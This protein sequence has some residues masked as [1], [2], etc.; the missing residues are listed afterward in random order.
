MNKN[1]SLK[2]FGKNSLKIVEE[3]L[4]E[5]KDGE[6][7][8]K[9]IACGLCASDLKVIE[10]KKEA[11][12]GITL[13]HEIVGE[14][15][16]SKNEMVKEKK[17]VSVFPSVVCR[18]CYSCNKGYYNLCRS[19]KSLGYYLDGGFARYVVVPREI[20]EI[21]GLIE[22]E[23]IPEILGAI[24]EPVGCVINSLKA[25][26]IQ[27]IE[28]LLIVGAGSLGLFHLIIANSY[29]KRVAIVDHN[30]DRL[31][32]ARELGARNT[33]SSIKGVEER[34]DAIVLTAPAYDEVST[35]LELLNERGKL[36]IF[37]GSRIDTINLPIKS[38]HYHE[39]TITGTHS[40]TPEYM[41]E[42]VEVIKNNPTSF[43]K[44]ITHIF[45]LSKWKDAIRYYKTRKAVKILITPD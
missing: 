21:G 8:I 6:V 1:L 3:P 36:N 12:I 9:V 30:E 18:N 27:D 29:K 31:N 39:R 22:I 25:I 15:V 35:I 32:L 23:G 28:N 37:A 24:I 38:F 44:V 41:K 33:L 26:G 7:L 2:I 14:I 40:T 13:G 45:K 34:Y 17:V 11:K 42:G 16:E 4:R 19:K 10:G 20:V 43:Q 5:I